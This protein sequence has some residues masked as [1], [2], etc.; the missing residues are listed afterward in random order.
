MF[1]KFTIEEGR[2]SYHGVN[3]ILTYYCIRCYP[4]LGIGICAIRIIPCACLDFRNSIDLP[5]DPFIV[6]NY[7]PRYS[8]VTKYKYYSILGQHNYWLIMD[9]IDIGTD[10]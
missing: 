4:Y 9:F 6:P 10:E 5:W 3:V 7:Q 1:P 2:N 8:S